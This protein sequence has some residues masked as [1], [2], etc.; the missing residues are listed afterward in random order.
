MKILH[1]INVCC[2]RPWPRQLL[3]RLGK[4][5]VEHPWRSIFVQQLEQ[6]EPSVVVRVV[7][8]GRGIFSV[9]ATVRAQE[10]KHFLLQIL[11][12]DPRR[13]HEFLRGRNARRCVSVCVCVCVCVCM[14][15]CVCVCVWVCV[16]ACV[17]A[18]K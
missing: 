4:R 2:V 12:V 3:V 1:N 8:Y 16:Y 18:C 7:I 15:A 13:V 10:W 11:F 9:P 5:F 6:L 17:Y 14:R